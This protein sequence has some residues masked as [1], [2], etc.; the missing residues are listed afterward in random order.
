VPCAPQGPDAAGRPAAD[1]PTLFRGLRAEPPA[2]TGS[3][4]SRFRRSRDGAG[5]RQRNRAARGVLRRIDAVFSANN[6]HI[7]SQF[8][9][10]AMF[11]GIA[12]M[13]RPGG[14]FALYG[15]FNYGGTYTSS[16]NAD[17]DRWPKARDPDSGIRDFEH[18]DTLAD[19]LG[20]HPIADHAMPANNRTLIWCKPA[21]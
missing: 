16:S 13:L 5:D 1:T 6:A 14:R 15:P 3:H 20:L 18:L 17:F 10:G 19:S 8:E 4:R 11:W 21:G 9:V 7:M 12:G 2:H